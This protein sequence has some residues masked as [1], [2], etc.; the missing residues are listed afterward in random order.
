MYTIAAPHRSNV[1]GTISISL[2][3][4]ISVSQL[5]LIAA[6]AGDVAG[7]GFCS[8]IVPRILYV[9]GAVTDGSSHPPTPTHLCSTDGTG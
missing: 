8:A 1:V 4:S 9:R 2:R 3:C 5:Y 6:A 7:A